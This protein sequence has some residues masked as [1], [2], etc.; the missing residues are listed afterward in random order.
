MR[1]GRRGF[2]LIELLV[3][4]AIIAILIALLLPA[5][6][7]AREAARRTQCKNN[8]KQIGIALHNY[9]DVA[10]SLPPGRVRVPVDGQGRCYSAYAF[11]LPHLEAQNLYRMIDFDLN[12]EDPANA[13]AMD[14]TI[15]YFLCPSDTPELPKALQL[16]EYGSK[17]APQ[18]QYGGDPP[19]D[20]FYP[21]HVHYFRALLGESPDEQVAY[22]RGKLDAEPDEQDKPYLAFEL[23]TLLI[24]MGRRAEAVDVAGRHLKHVNDP[25]G[26][27]FPQLCLEAGRVEAWR[28]A[29]KEQGDPVGYAAAL[30]QQAAK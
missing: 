19:F 25:N 6:Q 28:D 15:S 22:F 10:R 29:A 20:E 9:H 23:V 18:F 3:V 27:S 8:L 5:V 24:K 17:L 16:A 1:G 11:L 4:I 13:A 12:P 7:Q 21:A 2:T 30:A 26:F 14:Q